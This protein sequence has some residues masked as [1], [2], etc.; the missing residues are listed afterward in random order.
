M[1]LFSN[2]K[3]PKQGGRRKGAG[4][5]PLGKVLLRAKIAP[6]T[7]F[8]IH[9]IATENEVTFGKVVDAAFG[10]NVHICQIESNLR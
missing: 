10:K 9:T 3:K 5:K 2:M 4:R 8:R 7:L 6:E 1:A